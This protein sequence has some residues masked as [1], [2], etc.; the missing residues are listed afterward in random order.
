M[1]IGRVESFEALQLEVS[2]LGF[3]S[4]FQDHSIYEFMNFDSNQIRA[5]VAPT[6]L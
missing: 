5:L 1:A 6:Y 2:L 4:F 3:F